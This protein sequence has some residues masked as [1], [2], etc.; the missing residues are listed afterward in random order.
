MVACYQGPPRRLPKVLHLWPPKLLQSGEPRFS[1]AAVRCLQ[2]GCPL[3]GCF[4]AIFEALLEEL[5]DRDLVDLARQRLTTIDQA[6]EVDL[7][8]L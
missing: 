1:G 4:G 2:T 5:A 3:W 7:E 8:Q 6:I